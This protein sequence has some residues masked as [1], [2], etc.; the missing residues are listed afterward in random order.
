MKLNVYAIRDQ[1]SGFLTPTFETSD[2]VAMR[3]FQMACDATYNDH[4]LLGYRPQD[5]DLYC[6][7]TFDHKTGEFVPVN[8][9][10]LVCS[11]V[12]RRRPDGYFEGDKHD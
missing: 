11:G 10:R 1:L 4:S 12:S 2:A 9:I 6:V 7:A 5:F 3:N 8:P